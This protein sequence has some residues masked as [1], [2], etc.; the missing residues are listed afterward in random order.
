[1]DTDPNHQMQEA[2]TPATQELDTLRLPSPPVDSQ[3]EHEQHQQLQHQPL[4]P[5][6]APVAPVEAA[7]PIPA[8]EPAPVPVQ[9]PVMVQQPVQEIPVPVQAP[10]PVPVPATAPAPV[11]TM[12][13]SEPNRIAAL[14]MNPGPQAYTTAADSDEYKRSC[15]MNL[16]LRKK[17]KCIFAMAM[18]I[19]EFDGMLD[20]PPLTSVKRKE[21]TD[22]YV[23]KADDFKHEIKRR[24]H[25]FMHVPEE[26]SYFTD[27][28]KRHHPLKTKR[29]SVVMPQPNQWLNSALKKWLLERPMKPNDNDIEFLRTEIRQALVYL[30]TETKAEIGVSTVKVEA[31]PAAL[32]A[33]TPIKSPGATMTIPEGTPITPAPVLKMGEIVT[34]PHLYDSPSD[35]EEFKRSAA[36]TFLL[37]NHRPRTILAMALGMEEFNALLDHPPFTL[38]KKKDMMEDHIPRAEDYRFEIKRRAHFF[39]NMDEEVDYY[40]KALGRKN[41]LENM[42]GI[43]AVPQPNQWKLQQLKN[44]LMER[45]LKPNP[46]DS[47]FLRDV[48]KQLLDT[49]NSVLQSDPQQHV[50]VEKTPSKKAT[51]SSGMKSTWTA[52]ADSTATDDHGPGSKRREGLLLECITKQDA[53]LSAVNKQTQQQTILNKITVLTQAISGYQQETS[54]LRSTINDVDNRILTVEMRMA[55]APESAERLQVIIAKQQ[56]A[57]SQSES[58]IR[59]LE[60]LIQE[61]RRKIEGHGEELEQLDLEMNGASPNKGKK[62]K[63]EEGGL[64][65]TIHVV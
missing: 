23:P 3:Q 12:M 24:S 56:E 32:A 15:A 59:E 28:L 9:A 30:A 34:E 11:D 58:K 19:A 60:Q 41:P 31:A 49:L 45:P 21:L 39:M 18:G 46:K 27:E 36:A 35:S 7:E 48:I 47:A 37:R 62:R 61:S 64:V 5:A 51:P 44:W 57:K 8:P 55:E 20:R 52:I 43:V 65:E 29:S 22:L 54:S 63:L 10:A 26:A 16:T 40:T 25:F 2:A 42:R 17:P 6:P 50:M 53:I 14:V 33:L 1:M 4:P 38:V 13:E